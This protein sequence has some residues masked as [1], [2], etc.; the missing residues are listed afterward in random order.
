MASKEKMQQGSSAYTRLAEVYRMHAR[1]LEEFDKRPDEYHDL[2]NIPERQ[3][4]ELFRYLVLI[5]QQ[6]DE[7]FSPTA[8]VDQLWKDGMITTKIAQHVHV[9]RQRVHAILV[10]LGHKE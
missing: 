1:L 4:D 9:C 10:S 5:R 8:Q 6:G 3:W 7:E 2:H